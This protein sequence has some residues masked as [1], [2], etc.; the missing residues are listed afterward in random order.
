MKFLNEVVGPDGSYGALVKM[1]GV[2]W[3]I[4]YVAGEVRVHGVGAVDLRNWKVKSAPALVKKLVALKLKALPAEWH[5]AH[6]A[7][8]AEPA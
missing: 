4:S 2:E 7:L 5:A 3:A 8:Y 1:S 6:D